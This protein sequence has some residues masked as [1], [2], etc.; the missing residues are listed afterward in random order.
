MFY[1]LGE[2]FTADAATVDAEAVAQAGA[3]I[4]LALLLVPAVYATAGLASSH[5]EW[6][7]MT[8]GGMGL[9]VAVGALLLVV[10]PTN[11][12]AAMIGGYGAGAVVTLSRPPGTGFRHRAIGVAVG[13]AVVF[14]GF[15]VV[16]A[17][18]AWL[19]PALPFTAVGIADL[20]ADVDV[21]SEAEL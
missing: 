6:H 8:L 15:L 1:G 21:E 3:G 20:L 5:P 2:A 10:P 4:G 19:A 13:T 17:A 12:L 14:V 18:I 11:P 7:V 9:F 16:P